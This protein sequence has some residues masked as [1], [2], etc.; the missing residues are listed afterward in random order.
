MSDIRATIRLQFHREFTLDDA[1]HW[2]DYYAALG[3]SHVYASPLLAS[4]AGSTHGY[5]GVDPT[6]LD[7]ELGGEAALE[8]LVTRLRANGMGLILDIVPNHVAVGGSENPWWQDV[9]RWGRQSPYA[10]FFDIDWLSPD[11]LL[12]GKLLVP[13]L[14]APYEEVLNSGMLELHYVPESVGFE[15]AYHEH[16]FPIDPRHYGD[17]LRHAEHDALRDVAVQFDALQARQDAYTAVGELRQQLRKTLEADAARQ[18]LE[19]LFGLFDTRQEAGATRLHALL[20]RQSY[21]LAWWRTASD[22]INW[23]RFFDITELGGLRVELPEVFEATHALAFQLV[24]AGWVDGLRVDHVD[25]LADPGGYCRRL[26]ERLNALEEK[27]P[28][29]VPRHVALYVEKIL[30]DGE[31]LHE[32]WGVDG[33][34]GYEFMNEVSGLQHDPEGAAP[35][36]ALWH[37]VSGRDANFLVEVRQARHEM[38]ESALASEFDGCSRALLKLARCNLTTRDITL[39]SIKRALRALIVHFPVYRTYADDGGRPEQDAPFFQ[40]AMAGARGELSPPDVAVL[41]QLERWLGG[42]APSGCADVGARSL[43]QRAITR[44]QQLT[45]PVAAKAVEDTAGYRSAVLI[46]RND[47]G[48]DP[49]HF[50][51]TPDDFHA[52]CR[53]RLRHFPNTLITTATHDHKRGEDV[54]ARLAVI[55]EFAEDFAR[56]V[57]RWRGLAASLRR[58]L[59]QG[60]APSAGDELILY[61]MV[62]GAWAPELDPD[63]TQAMQRFTER[64]GQWQQKALR[65]AKLRSHWLWPDNDYEA[66][67]RDFLEALLTDP[68]LRLD[69]AGAARLLDLP[70]AV[71]GLTQ[72]VLR[73]TVPGVPDLYQGTE[74]W[75]YSLVD[76]DN[77]REVDYRAR[78]SALQAQETPA[79]ALSHWPDGHVKQAIIT[80][81]LALRQRYSRLFSEGSYVPVQVEGE[82]AEHILAFMRQQGS[83]SLLVVVPRLPMVLLK[84]ATL[85][86]IASQCWED[87]R[88]QVTA[89]MQGSWRSIL[90]NASLRL[91]EG[92]MSP[93]EVLADL[94]VG[95][96]VRDDTPS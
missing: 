33:T 59:P 74:F 69:I 39:G 48:F 92:E 86:C 80:R 40:Q 83:Q 5:D 22:D 25:G 65:E 50:S 61:Q 56:H 11:P 4:R 52:A 36:Q 77:R 15:I 51:R 43:R 60:P 10:E 57:E 64:L 29:E 35:L 53:E 31:T 6:R 18:A 70:G 95:V 47:V 91:D 21:R 81:I 58:D 42:E 55:S 88:L 45:S 19:G 27:R 90:T 62:L 76:P 67:C 85:P 79:D 93:G 17:I 66:A 82:R 73:L 44:F 1:A 24:E 46:S 75:D 72:T 12:A 16:R 49:Q 68:T 87:T 30:A 41:E 26:R 20:E 94:P 84:T 96:F 14:G 71:N 34:T 38:L 37:A 89:P 8:R 3:V 63:D 2:V 13:F 78:Q 32:D 9:L 7:P 28:A 54:R 23:R